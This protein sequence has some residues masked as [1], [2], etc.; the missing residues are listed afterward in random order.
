M[1]IQDIYEQYKIMPSL[2]QHMYRVSGV[3]ALICDSLNEKVDRTAILT[4]CLLHDMGN[5]LKFNLDLFPT[6]LEPE[7][8]DYWQQV[9]DEYRAKYGN[10]EHIATVAIAKDLHVESKVIDLIDSILFS[11][12][13]ANFESTDFNRK[14]AAYSDMRVEPM[15]VVTLAARLDD[16]NKRFKINKPNEAAKHDF[17]QE[18]ARYLSQIEAQIFTKTELQPTDITNEKVDQYQKELMNW[19]I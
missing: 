12:A 2:Q 3:A 6:F 10:D 8:R 7:G 4:A 13:R 16:G 14:I 19:P 17:F 11:Y 15:G 9:Q 18:M 1:T 5:I